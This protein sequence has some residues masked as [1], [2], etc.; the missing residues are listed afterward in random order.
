M[1]SVLGR[2][3]MLLAIGAV[4]AV[5]VAVIAIPTIAAGVRGG[6]MGA[7]R[8]VEQ[9]AAAGIDHRYDGDFPYFVGGGV[10]AF[11]CDDDG[12]SE[13][14]FAG[15]SARRRCTATTA[16]SAARCASPRVPRRSPT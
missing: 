10:A 2:P 8:F 1:I 14:Y 11:D 12:R 4:L 7:P 3:R 9:A 15:G 5:V 6:A 13:L 16:R